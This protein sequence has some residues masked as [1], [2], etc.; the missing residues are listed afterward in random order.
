[1]ETRLVLCLADMELGGTCLEQ[2][3]ELFRAVRLALTGA[4]APFRRDVAGHAIQISLGLFDEIG[5]I[6]AQQA[7]VDFLCKVLGIRPCPDSA[8]DEPGQICVPAPDPTSDAC[9]FAVAH[10][11]PCL[12]LCLSN[13]LPSLNRWGWAGKWTPKKVCR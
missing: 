8:L 12:L 1:M 7:Q 3:I 11:T 6:G 4:H 13:F 2:Q 5:L 9:P 10:L